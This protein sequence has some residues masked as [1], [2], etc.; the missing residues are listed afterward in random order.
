MKAFEGWTPFIA[1]AVVARTGDLFAGL[2]WPIG[3]ALMT[4]VIGTLFLKETN[5]ISIHEETTEAYPTP[6]GS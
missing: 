2:W 5:H 3:V 4:F 6:A 1:T